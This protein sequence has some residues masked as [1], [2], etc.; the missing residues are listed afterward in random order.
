MPI[1]ILMPALSPTMEK[2]NL[3]QWMKAVGDRLRSDDVV[4]EVETDKATIEVAA[5]AEGTLTKILVPAGTQDVRV[6]QVIG[7]ITG[8]NE[9]SHPTSAPSAQEP[10][11]TL[12]LGG[13]STRVIPPATYQAASAGGNGTAARVFASPI[14][15][16]MMAGA[17]LE[18]TMVHGTG[19][20]GRIVER[21]VKAAI[22]LAERVANAPE[23]PSDKTI[24]FPIIK[25]A[26]EQTQSGGRNSI[27]ALFPPGSF[28]EVR[29]DAMRLTISHRLVESVRTVPHFYLMADCEMDSLL[30]LR[31]RIN[32][33]APSRPDGE[34][35]YRLSINHF[36]I[37]ALA[38]ALQHV[39]DANV[40]FTDDALLRHRHSDISVA[41]AIPGGLV[42]PIIRHAEA[43]ILSAIANE[44]VDLAARA[45]NRKLRVEEYQGGTAGLSNLGMY[46]VNQFAAIINPPQSTMLAI[47]AAEDRLI[48]RRGATATATMASITLSA[49]H[50]ALDGAT[51]AQL[52]SAFKKAIE[53]PMSLLV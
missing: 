38:L 20:R 18:P 36:I 46:G 4:A 15:R 25:P 35:V 26:S 53:H 31:Q 39:P 10:P 7:L 11:E 37:K 40:T 3:V 48:V 30:A 34:P 21:D 33:D 50:R 16:R 51:A 19:P 9:T 28:E 1:N 44:M 12:A 13:M 42:T 23:P 14:A 24:S 22:T 49:D 32:E 47:G 45:R 29:H 52:L 2:G 41:V 17:N 43:K 5:G 27:A 8:E 6:S